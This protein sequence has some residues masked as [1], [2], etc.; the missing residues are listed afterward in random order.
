MTIIKD[1]VKFNHLSTYPNEEQLIAPFLSGFDI[2]WARR[3]KAYNTNISVYFLKPEK[4]ITDTFGFEEEIVLAISDYKTIEP[5]TIQSVES[6]I[7]DS[8]AKGRVEQ[9][10]YFLYTNDPNGRHWVSEYISRN[11]QSRIP[12]VFTAQD[13]FDAKSDN[14]HIRTIIAQQ[15]YTRDLFNYS[16]PID[17]DFYFFGRE[18]IIASYVDSIKQSQNVGI[19][20]LR[21]TGKTS[22]LY[23]LQRIF[24]ADKIGIYI[25]IDC[26]I[27]AIRMLRWNELLYRICTDIKKTCDLKTNATKDEKSISDSFINILKEYDPAKKICL[28]FDE[29]EY[30]SP[31]AKLDKHWIDDFIPFWQTLWAAQSQ[32]RILSNILAGVNPKI[33][34]L[35]TFNQVQNPIFGIIKPSYLRGL[36]VND[37]RK[38]IRFFGKRM[39][40]KFTEDAIQ[41]LYNRYGGHPLLTRVACSQINA[42][43]VATS[44]KRPIKI[45]EDYLSRNETIIENELSFYCKHV[46][47]ELKDFY[48]EE[49]EMLE[50]LASKRTVDFMELSLD[51]SLTRH[52]V[53]YGLITKDTKNKPTFAIPVIGQHIG[54]E[55]AKKEQRKAITYVVPKELR[56]SWL[57]RRIETI[58]FELR[59]LENI[60]QSKSLPS[61]YGKSSFPEADKFYKIKLCTDN[62]TFTSFINT[63]NKCFVESIS[64][65]GAEKGIHQYFQ[66]TIKTKYSILWDALNR[67]KAYR[68]HDFHLKL[69]KKAE[70]DFNKYISID[71]ENNRMSQVDEP[72][73]R[74][75]Q[76]VLDELLTAILQE[77]NNLA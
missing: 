7:D 45:D 3:R 50:L 74:L 16:L 39:G 20:G 15:L 38:M 73:F 1:D 63:C 9:T 56:E 60:I 75:Q 29:I 66:Y 64:S 10:V 6:I 21:K 22:I 49:Y 61:L 5:R 32:V 33:A 27:P 18:A 69:T 35:D 13:I 12:V 11:P 47:S 17:N 77:I 14:W 70:A 46:V 58:I 71:L 8:P 52:L 31:L 59:S 34:E 25:Y 4:N 42:S 68:N 40:L 62:T 57:A 44:S 37:L 53:S 36:E 23:K 43:V 72:W 65:Y 41:Y 28:V 30:I 2:T 19:F 55:Y 24:N 67:I 51:Q 54:I 76:C 48:P 26:K